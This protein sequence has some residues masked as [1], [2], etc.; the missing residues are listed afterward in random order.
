[1][2]AQFSPQKRQ[3]VVSNAADQVVVATACYA[4]KAQHF[5][6]G[7]DE[8]PLYVIDLKCQQR[9]SPLYQAAEKFENYLQDKPLPT[10]GM[11]ITALVSCLIRVRRK[12]F[13]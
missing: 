5:M 10:F 9:P 7:C 1:M 2:A 4:E 6:A 3:K 11:S 8:G 12:G 13:L